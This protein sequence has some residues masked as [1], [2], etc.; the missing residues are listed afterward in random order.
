MVPALPDRGITI[1]INLAEKFAQI[2]VF[3]EVEEGGVFMTEE[4]KEVSREWEN[5]AEF[6]DLS[7]EIGE[8]GGR[9][10]GL[11]KGKMTYLAAL[12]FSY[13]PE[14]FCFRGA[15]SFCSAELKSGISWYCI[16][17]IDIWDVK[18]CH[19]SHRAALTALEVTGASYQFNG[20]TMLSRFANNY[21]D[22]VP[23]NIT[24]YNGLTEDMRFCDSQLL[25]G[26]EA[27]TDERQPV[28]PIP[29]MTSY[30][31]PGFDAD[32]ILGWPRIW[33]LALVYAKA[34]SAVSNAL[35]V[36]DLPS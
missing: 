20:N 23:Q 16:G 17:D 7:V 29:L 35:I 30:N 18:A 6:D 24:E 4:T 34:N 5:G 14:E 22:M 1:S 27:L 9:D 8:I 10:Q 13:C 21:V 12:L 33:K 31:L 28:T 36:S 19:I 26:L 11:M 15:A 25:A 3:G 32:N 2:N